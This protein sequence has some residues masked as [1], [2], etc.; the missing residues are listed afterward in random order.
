MKKNLKKAMAMG[1]ATTM[2]LAAPAAVSA[3]GN[4]SDVSGSHVFMFKSVGNA[5]GVIM[6]EGFSSYMEQVGENCT[7][8][9]PAETTV[10]AQ[11]QLID[12]SGMQIHL[13]FY[14]W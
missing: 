2:A 1:L 8:K 14:K 5:F 10:A 3:A 12:Y 4:T 9:S 6:Y 11:V 13:H 7:E